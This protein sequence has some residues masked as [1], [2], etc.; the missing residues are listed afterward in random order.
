[1]Q[2]DVCVVGAGSAGLSAAIYAA[3]EGLRTL[4]LER[5]QPGGQAARSSLIENYF[6]H[7]SIPGSELGRIGRQQA[8]DFGA[9]FDQ[10]HILE[11]EPLVTEVARLVVVATGTMFER[12]PGDERAHHAAV[13]EHLALVAGEDVVVVGGG[14]AAGQA[15]TFLAATARSVSLVC[16]GPNLE[17]S[18]STYL[19]KRIL[20]QRNI[21]VQCGTQVLSIEANGVQCRCRNP[22]GRDG[23]DTK[24]V[25]VMA[26]AKPNAAWTGLTLDASGF[27]KTDAQFRTSRAGVFAIGDVRSGSMKRIA[28]AAGEGAL[29]IQQLHAAMV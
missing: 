13:R 10:R 11:L 25:F 9:E 24:H 3:S 27:I 1:M 4:I 7:T 16:R 20:L 14:N 19:I 26:G 15:A 5:D 12:V 18:M 23:F 28:A 21:S 6:G 29:V 22:S 17:P 2:Y 8:E